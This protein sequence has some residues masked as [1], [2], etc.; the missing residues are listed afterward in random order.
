MTLNAEEVSSSKT[1]D[2][3]LDQ[4]RSTA[5]AIQPDLVTLRRSIHAD[6]EV[7]LHLPRTQQRVL[8]ALEDLNLEIALGSGLSSVT[9]VL[10]GAGDGPVV[11]L[12]GDMDALPINERTGL[13][14][15]AGGE[16]MHAC[17]HDMHTAAL[18]GAARLLCSVREHLHGSVIFMFQP[19]EELGEGAALM[20]AEGVLD[21]AGAEPMAAY[22]IH[23]VSGERGVFSTRGGALMAGALELRLELFGAGGH[24]AEPHLAVNP[25][26]ALAAVI[27]AVETFIATRF[28]AFDPVVLSVTQVSSGDTLN[29]IPDCARLGASIRVLSRAAQEKIRS[30]LPKLLQSVVTAYGCKAEIE[31]EVVCAPTVNDQMLAAGAIST[32]RRC[33]GDDRVWL[34]PEPVMGS[35]DFGQVLDRIPGA[36]LFLRATPPGG[37]YLPNHSPRICFDDQV[38]GDQALALAALSLAHLAPVDS[39]ASTRS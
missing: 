21:V 10:K 32:L 8:T 19:G 27:N 6:P 29:V 33:F 30:E 1:A 37:E 14:Y 11:L 9:A 22:G 28:E 4:L 7:G 5:A 13:P 36:F 24:A 16:T 3:L 23:V 20:L 39:S 15:A 17:G 12:R 2:P 38:L 35:E 18:V 34:T 31:L 26:P 25:I